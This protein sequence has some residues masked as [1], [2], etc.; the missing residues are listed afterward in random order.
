MSVYVLQQPATLQNDKRAHIMELLQESS[1]ITLWLDLKLLRSLITCN[2]TAPKH[3][4]SLLRI[5]MMCVVVRFLYAPPPPATRT[6]GDPQSS[7]TEGMIHVCYL[8]WSLWRF[9]LS[10]AQLLMYKSFW[11]T[12][13]N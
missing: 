12:E 13:T 1:Q 8:S 3:Y 4:C 6:L 7:Q 11:G 9:S 10:R 2:E 5:V